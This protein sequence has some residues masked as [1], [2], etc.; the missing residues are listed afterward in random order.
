[1]FTIT[2]FGAVPD[3]TTNNAPAIM[4]AIRSCHAAGGGVVRVPA[5]AFFS[6]TIRLLSGVEL[7]LEEGAHLI[8]SLDP[9]EI[10]NTPSPDSQV[11]DVSGFFIGAF[12]AKNVAITGKGV[13]D[14]QGERVFFEDGSDEGTGEGP[15]MSSGFRPRM[16][17]LEGVK[18]LRVEGVT[19]QDSPLWTLHMAGCEDVLIRG[20]TIR[21]DPRGT[22]ND[23][24]DPDACKRVL[25]EDCDITAGDDA[26][27]IKC[28]KSSYEQYGPCKD[29]EIR[30]CRLASHDSALKIGTENTGDVRRVHV[31]HC[32]IRDCSRAFTVLARDGGTVEDIH[33]H[34]L[35]GAVR[36]YHGAGNRAFMPDWWGKGEAFCLSATPRPGKTGCA[37]HIQNV[38]LEDCD[39]AVESSVFLAGEEES[40]LEAITLRDIRLTFR[41]QGTQEPGTFDEQPSGRGKYAH[42]VPALYARRVKGLVTENVSVCYNGEANAWRKVCQAED[43]EEA[44]F[45][46]V[47]FA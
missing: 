13:I 20:V 45:S 16:F 17:S 36:A 12:G 18:G 34:H 14:G 43:C 39:L 5:G 8:G 23:G 7:H 3:G 32:E 11:K 28:S 24:I 21:N 41:R 19:I 31:H 6:G 22:N 2:D 26:I 38:R 29:I 44:D 47:R 25:I 30:N 15:K 1:M 9:E 27:T 35:V 46:G 4:R 40:L 42:I 33:V 37:G 10:E